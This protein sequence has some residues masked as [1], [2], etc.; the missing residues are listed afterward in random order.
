MG[1]MHIDNLYKNIE[2]LMFKECYALEKIHGTSANVTW[3]D[4]QV[5]LHSGGEKHSRFELLFDI[6]KLKSKFQELFDGDVI[7]FG[8]A[9]GGKQQGMSETYGK[10]LKFIVFDVKVGD[11]WLNVINAEDVAK[12]FELEFVSYN[13]IPCD[14]T[15]ISRERDTISIQAK[16]N[17]I[18][19]DKPREG[20]VI[21]PLEECTNN[22]GNRIIVKHKGD[23]FMETKTKREVN[24]EKV[25]ILKESNAI[26]DEWVTPMR[27]NHVLDKLGNPN[28]MKET[29]NVI[30]AMIE[31]VYREAKG[32]IEE[33]QNVKKSI[34]IKTV[35]LY[36]KS[37]SKVLEDENE[38]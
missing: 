10:E 32:E 19:E 22:R 37:I 29:K 23:E 17:G 5:V 11:T 12:K 26:A 24:P 1:Y 4:E 20:I 33:S 36:K 21:R 3:K 9:Y 38:N 25:K 30:T 16:R 15:Y 13:Q 34:G 6:E 31:D 7:L 8:E 35:A 27:L 14:L 2:I 18:K 28:D